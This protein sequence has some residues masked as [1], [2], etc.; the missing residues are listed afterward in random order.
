MPK[1]NK[2]SMCVELVVSSLSEHEKLQHVSGIDVANYV[3]TRLFTETD[4]PAFGTHTSRRK[5]LS[6]GNGGAIAKQQQQQQ[7]ASKQASKA[8]L[9]EA[10]GG[11]GGLE[12][13]KIDGMERRRRQNK[14]KE[15]VGVGPGTDSSVDKGA[16]RKQVQL[17]GLHLNHDV[18]CI[19]KCCSHSVVF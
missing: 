4:F 9:Q 6:I 3:N 14:R 19:D 15:V 8:S 18:G 13:R 5:A 1:L 17:D 2:C 11:T 7:Q 16:G 10:D 12:Q